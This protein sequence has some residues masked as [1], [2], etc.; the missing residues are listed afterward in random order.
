MPESL[1]HADNQGLVLNVSDLKFS[2]GAEPLIDLPEFHIRPEERVAIIGPSGCGKTTLMHLIAGLIRPDS[3][4][5]ELHGQEITQLKE[6]EVD[7]LRGREVGIVFQRLHLM[8]AISV[9]NN[10]LLAQKLARVNQDKQ[11]AMQLLQQLGIAEFKDV[12]PGNLSQ[13]QAQ[14]A[15][16]ARAVVHKP[17]LVIGD[18]PTSALDSNNAREA[19]RLLTDLS[20]EVGFGLLVVTHDERVRS[21]MDRVLTLGDET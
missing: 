15:A 20:K 7:R 6:W 11:H 1:T 12:L 10:L 4:S 5:I 2:Y 9:L 17:T 16:I 19:I 13:G 8:P 21:G 3:G 14:R 18:E